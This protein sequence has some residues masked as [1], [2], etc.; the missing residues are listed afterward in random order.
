[1]TRKK[2]SVQ[3]TP[4][5]ID[6]KTRIQQDFQSE[7]GKLY[8]RLL[9]QESNDDIVVT[10]NS[11]IGRMVKSLNVLIGMMY[12]DDQGVLNYLMGL[13]SAKFPSFQFG[14]VVSPAPENV[15]ESAPV[16]APL[17]APE[18]AVVAKP[19]ALVEPA[20]K[21]S[22][23]PRAW[24]TICCS[25]GSPRTISPKASPASAKS[26]A[27]ASPTSDV[28]EP[29][30]MMEEVARIFRIFAGTSEVMKIV[31]AKDLMGR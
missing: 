14:E 22:A 26:A 3:T 2:Q 18:K 4:V 6:L 25:I 24:P 27:P 31:I 11:K 20:P 19:I 8:D 12:P 23:T 17:P 15:V 9:L 29:G 13:V 5:A 10:L 16:E 21:V 28:Q 30:A 7:T 1:M